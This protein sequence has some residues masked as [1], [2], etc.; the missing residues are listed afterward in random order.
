MNANDKLSI[1]I[2]IFLYTLQGIPMGLCIS[3][4]LIFKEKG[5]SYESLSLF[6]LVSI[7]FSLKILWAPL[8]DTYYLRTIGQRKSWILPTQF[9]SG[10]AMIVGSSFVRNWLIHANTS[11]YQLTGYFMLLYFM[12]ATQDIAVDGW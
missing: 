9:I 7:P 8:V 10:I 11:I 4:P 1:C 12:M 6:S 2:L 3:L 5:I